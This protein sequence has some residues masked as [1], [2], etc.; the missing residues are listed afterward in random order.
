MTS[1]AAVAAVPCNPF[2]PIVA[3]IFPG[4]PVIVPNAV[5]SAE[6]DEKD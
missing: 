2:V 3:S 6:E 4:I 1:S 5:F